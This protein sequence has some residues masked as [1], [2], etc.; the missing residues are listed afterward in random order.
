[1]P[2]LMMRL[3]RRLSSSRP[4]NIK[5][6]SIGAMGKARRLSQT[7]TRAKA[8][9]KYKSKRL[10]ETKYTPV[11]E[12]KMIKGARIALGIFSSFAKMGIIGRLKNNKIRFPIYMETTIDQ[13]TVGSSK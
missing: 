11:K 7:A 13:N 1:M 5:P 2:S 6:S 4:P 3:R 9:I 12:K 10:K 8:I